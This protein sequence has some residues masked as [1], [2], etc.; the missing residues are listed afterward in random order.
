M[1]FCWDSEAT[2]TLTQT[3][4]TRSR[5]TVVGRYCATISSASLWGLPLS[6]SS[7][8]AALSRVMIPAIL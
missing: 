8:S 2:G 7:S 6:A 1:R 3:V 5:G 4:F